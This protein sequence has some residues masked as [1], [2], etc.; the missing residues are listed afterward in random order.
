MADPKE[1]EISA[2]S[3]EIPQVDVKGKEEIVMSKRAREIQKFLESKGVTPERL[4]RLATAFVPKENKLPVAGKFGKVYWDETGADT[5]FHHLRIT[6]LDAQGK[7]VGDCS[8]SSIQ[9]Q[10][11]PDPKNMQASLGTK[12][13]YFLR[14]RPLNLQ[15]S[16]IA[17]LELANT[18]EGKDFTAVGSEYKLRDFN[19]GKGHE[20]DD[21]AI[22][23]CVTRI[24]YAIELK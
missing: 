8:L 21:L 19:G 3:V 5:R 15:L 12:G 9:S 11:A 20:S 16:R 18:L 17:I 22:K 7:V 10:V 1:P 24:C 2:E 13:G 6:A 23:N 14:V 4:T